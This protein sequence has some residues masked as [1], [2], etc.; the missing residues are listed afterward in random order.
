MLI[1][2]VSLNPPSPSP[3][4]ICLCSG[5]EVSIW[6][7]TPHLSAKCMDF[8]ADFE[9]SSIDFRLVRWSR[10]RRRCVRCF[11]QYCLVV[12]GW[13]LTEPIRGTRRVI[14]CPCMPT[15]S[16][17][18]WFRSGTH[19]SIENPNAYCFES[20]AYNDVR[21]HNNLSVLRDPATQPGIQRRGG[22][23]IESAM[24]LQVMRTTS[25]L[26]FWSSFPVVVFYFANF[27][28]FFWGYGDLILELWLCVYV[29]HN[30]LIL[31]RTSAVLWLT[32]M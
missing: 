27:T 14:I 31:L 29:S 8:R 4:S 23:G 25:P 3:R 18:C 9:F 5:T 16:F 2:F 22:G 10:R 6:S 26:D 21:V 1:F 15:R 20:E 12:W 30:D 24:G 17:A 7:E 28:L 32:F 13:E 11:L 19:W